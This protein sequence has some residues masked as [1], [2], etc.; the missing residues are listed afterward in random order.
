MFYVLDDKKAE[1]HCQYKD[2]LP[3]Q[4]PLG[5]VCFIAIIYY[6][7]TMLKSE[8]KLNS[9]EF[10]Q[11]FENGQRLHTD[12]LTIIY[13]KFE[14]PVPKIFKAAVVVSKKHT[15]SA[16][17]RNYKRRVIWHA[18]SVLYKES[19]IPNNI[20]LVFILKKNALYTRP[21]DLQEEMK[22]IITKI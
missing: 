17:K 18:L 4:L 1:P 5:V 9:T 10:K 16:I 3:Q 11:V 13:T 15:K 6:S 8:N 20:S 7:Y 19:L 14:G 21:R 12:S 2:S 22:K